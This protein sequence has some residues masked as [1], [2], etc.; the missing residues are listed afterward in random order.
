MRREQCGY[1]SVRT[2]MLS[3]NL[4]LPHAKRRCGKWA[5]ALQLLTTFDAVGEIAAV[6]SGTVTPAQAGV[7][8][9]LSG[10]PPARE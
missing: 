6:A 7:Q 5:S 4:F 2:Q 9:R 1:A 8:R 3:G 10:F